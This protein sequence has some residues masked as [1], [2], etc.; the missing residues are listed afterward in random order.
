[1]LSEIQRPHM[2]MYERQG[3][4]NYPAKMYIIN[5]VQSHFFIKMIIKM[6]PHSWS[7]QTVIIV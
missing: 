6:L 5:H 7:T 2:K 1:M 4:Y 3:S